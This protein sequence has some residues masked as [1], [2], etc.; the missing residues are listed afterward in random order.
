MRSTLR[1]PAT[2]LLFLAL[3]PIIGSAATTDQ[4][5]AAGDSHTVGIATGGS[6]FTW[7]GN[8]SGQLGD[9]TNTSR[10]VPRRVAGIDNVVSVAAGAAHTLVLKADGTVFSFG[11]NNAGQLGDGTT[12][13]R[14]TPTQVSGLTNIT[15]IAAGGDHSVA[16]RSDGVL[17][18]WGSNGS[19]E[20]GDATTT[21]RS[22]PVQLTRITSVI[23][24]AAGRSHTL[25]LRSDGNAWSW[26]NDSQG[27]L[28]DDDKLATKNV[29]T[30]IKKITGLASIAAGGFHSFAISRT[31]VLYAWGSNQVGQLGDGTTTQRNTPVPVTSLT[32]V[33]KVA[34]GLGHSMAIA[35][36]GSTYAWGDNSVGQLGDGTTSP[37]HAP[38]LVPGMTGL[39]AI[40]A[41]LGHTVV[42]KPGNSVYAWGLNDSGQVGNGVFG[43]HSVAANVLN[44]SAIRQVAAGDNF[45]LA[46]K[47]DGTVS[48]WGDNSF[49]QLGDG[50]RTSR[51]A[52]VAI[53]GLTNVT[54]IAAGARHALA[55]KTDGS[56][57]GWGDNASGQLGDGSTTARL[58]PVRL[59][60]IS[61]VVA[62]AA[63][64]D[65]SVGLRADGTVWEWGLNSSGQ[66]GITAGAPRASPLQVPTLTN[67]TATA[68]G[69]AFTLALRA[70][71]T[72]W[73]WGD[74][75]FGQLGIGKPDLKKDKPTQITALTGIA[76]IF[77]GDAH[78]FAL[79]RNGTLYAWGNNATGQL[80]DG[81]ITQRSSPGTVPGVTNPAVIAGGTDHSLAVKPNGTMSSWGG[82]IL[83]ELGDGTRVAK[84]APVTVAGISNAIAADTGAYF[85]IALRSDGTVVAWGNN[86]SG[87]LGDGTIGR[88]IS[89]VLVLA[90]PS[91][92][93]SSPNDATTWSAGVSIPL[94]A[95][96]SNLA[97]RISKVEYFDGPTKIGEAAV[98]PF[99]VGWSSGSPGQH[100]LT[101]KATDDFGF[102]AV[103]AP[104]AIT[105][106]EADTD[107]NGI[108]DTWE[109]QNFGY[110]G[111]DP[112]ADPD[113]DSHSNLQE[114]MDGT[115]PNDYFNGQS[116]N[117]VVISG[118]N[119][120]SQPGAFLASPFVVKVTN[121]SGAA[122]A[123]APVT[124][125]VIEGGGLIASI[126]N[127]STSATL[128]TRTG[129]DGA[130]IAFYL[131]PSTPQIVSHITASAGAPNAQN[132]AAFA[133]TTDEPQSGQGIT[134]TPDQIDALVGAGASSTLPLTL[135][136]NGSQTIPFNASVV[137]GTVSNLSYADSDQSG[138]PI[139]VWND[140]SLSGT[141]LNAISD[142]DEG[143]EPVNLSFVFPYFNGA[144]AN[145]FV[146]ANGFITLG[147][148]AGDYNYFQF[149]STDGAANEIAAFHTDLNTDDSSGGSGDVYFQDFGDHAIFQ[150]NH[151]ERYSQDG[152]STFQIVLQSDGAIL[153]YYK[154]LTGTIDDCVV[155]IQ[156]ASKN[157]GLT[158]AYQ[159]SYLKN[160]L[161]VRIVETSKW[162][163]VAPPSGS[164][165]AGQSM[166]L[167][168]KLNARDFTSGFYH[169]TIGISSDNATVTPPT[170]PVR[171]A[172]GQTLQVSL[173]APPAG[174]RFVAG[175]PILL[176]AEASDAAGIA[177]VEFFDGATKV[178]E[179]IAPP[180]QGTIQAMTAGSHVLT[181]RATNVSAAVATSLPVQI[182][183]EDDTNSD[184]LGD[185][186]ELE[187]FGTLNVNANDD[188]DGDGLT[189]LQEFLSGTN[190]TQF[191]N[192]QIPD[193]PIVGG[194]QAHVLPGGGAG[195]ALTVRVVNAVGE[196]IPNAPVTFRITR[197]AGQLSITSDRTAP[198]SSTVTVR[199]DGLGYATVYYFAP[200]VTGSYE[201]TAESGEGAIVTQT[202]FSGRITRGK[203]AIIDLGAN[204]T[205]ARIANNGMVLLT[206]GTSNFRW[207][208][209]TLEPFTG[210][211]EDMNN[212]GIVGGY[213]DDINGNALPAT[214]SPQQQILAVP[215]FPQ[216]YINRDAGQ[217]TILCRL[218][219]IGDN[220]DLKYYDYSIYTT[221]EAQTKCFPPLDPN[222]IYG[223]GELGVKVSK[224]G[225]GGV[226]YT[227]DDAG[228]IYS[229]CDP[230]NAWATH[231]L[232]QGEYAFD[233]ARADDGARNGIAMGD[234]SWVWDN[235]RAQFFFS[236]NKVFV[237]RARGTHTIGHRDF[238]FL[239]SISAHTAFTRSSKFQVDGH[240]V[241][242]QPL[243]LN[244]EGFV[245]GFGPQGYLLY[246]NGRSSA[247]TLTSASADETGFPSISAINH[248]TVKITNAAGDL[249]DVESPQMVGYFQNYDTGELRARIWKQDTVANEYVGEDLNNY[250]GDNSDWILRIATDINDRGMI[251]GWADHKIGPN[252]YDYS[253]AVLL[254]PAELMVDGNRDGEMSF[255]DPD[256]HDADGTTAEKPY[257]FWINDDHDTD[258]GDLPVNGQPDG[259][260][261]FIYYKRDLEDFTRLWVTFKG[262]TAL[263]KGAGVTAE[264]QMGAVQQG[265][266]PSIRVFRHTDEAHDYGLGYVS[267][268]AI[269]TAQFVDL[270]SQSEIG[271]VAPGSPLDLTERCPDLI[272]GLSEIHPNLHFLF[273]GVTSGKGKL[274]LVLKK[275]GNVIGIYPALSL[276]LRDI[277]TMY[278]H[279]ALG[280]ADPWTGFTFEA[281]LDETNDA[282]IFVHGW[283]LSPAD[284]ANFAETM[285]KRLWWRGFKGRY[286]AVRWDT[287]YN[288]TDHGWVPYVGQPIDA[289]L[290]RYNDSEHNAWMS[291]QALRNFVNNGLPAG[292][293]RDVVAHSMGNV[294][295]GAA[296][297]QGMIVN[298]YALLNA[299]IPAACYDEDS[300]LR[301]TPTEKNAAILTV[302]LWDSNTTPDDDT[303]SITRALAY[304]GR[305]KNVAGNLIS[306]YL[307]EDYATSYA[308]ELNNV[309][310]KPPKNLA[311]LNRPEYGML[312]TNFEYDRAAS[313][314]RK[315]YKYNFP[316]NRYLSDPNEAEPYACRTWAKALGA[317]GRTR[318]KL[319]GEGVNLGTPAFGGANGLNTEHSGE[320]NRDIQELVPFYREV[321]RQLNIPQNP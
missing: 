87:Q 154:N 253:R 142:A 246:G 145:V 191:Y 204:V 30:Q 140:I 101:A 279:K 6:L 321:L 20:L 133:A 23:G 160:N 1:S 83:G 128:Q 294:V 13:A 259:D 234:I 99:T 236:G 3:L 197:G 162:L 7:G 119:Q 29:P 218:G 123:N 239:V 94:T 62:I 230:P 72:A 81:T 44:L 180:Y 157:K 120:H 320:F 85:S 263:T 274:Q 163:E 47:T 26:G 89:A 200:G 122:L 255:E 2:F 317:E 144:Y 290:S 227:I 158:V 12:A 269:A 309:L 313:P 51:L 118:D 202:T 24:I 276:D 223:R 174:A 280:G 319:T 213:V 187:F 189:N 304:R 305:L 71:G 127:G 192:G 33:E 61:N 298:N 177:R 300:N 102:V 210:H 258:A 52:P 60:A 183:I 77:A 63:G 216:K 281:A 15:A 237:T 134:V 242:F 166:Q 172:V 182:Q 208:N 43:A 205:P 196:P 164:L 86:L 229:A 115:D 292:Y 244:S 130:A 37:R 181:A 147:G 243:T 254:V 165:D 275:G 10:A 315:L 314:G 34:G 238:D 150:F 170:V 190:P 252:Q 67:I 98:S 159:R 104:V 267:D 207:N 175:A 27:Q 148:A 135:T 262:I 88:E 224:V 228:T 289:Y 73:S 296:L 97:G 256:I 249:V 219:T 53:T 287:Y 66:L 50:S 91:V 18:A 65:H 155:G 220:L 124:F 206:S 173:V 8:S 176:Q 93:L 116:S 38:T 268:N 271:L 112:N 231:N 278:Q 185:N 311:P 260:N 297:Q 78:A 307:P 299:A 241:D 14:S 153:F 59:T 113:G 283:R 11:A 40:A 306:F 64:A 96:A 5:V 19:G 151:V 138:G 114:L 265:P 284:T 100:H 291:G 272:N 245:L 270:Q 42:C 251:I 35:N 131:Q 179:A 248:A 69:G 250:I 28:G 156:N 92:T 36:N 286:A 222:G 107:H 203:Y 194:D 103:S 22:R 169:G 45:A 308:W 121:A 288:E 266:N 141:R 106:E 233:Y 109:I 282:I 226:V 302:H 212:S 55:L 75:A 39:T 211:A 257:R 4:Q 152:F 21:N 209:G 232:W 111:V 129:A 48:A 9:G 178:G 301:P 25:A 41:G 16:L 110:I 108:R 80:G 31:G 195:Q 171:M 126:A 199:A 149:P 273:E 264:L 54:S 221:E 217:G 214:W 46:L 225:T 49:G 285:F 201:V 316:F 139:F 310:T 90:L 293:T 295:V 70:D 84:L 32:S 143:T 74:N 215:S 117:L 76:K 240:D 188:L 58:A 193:L 235:L 186:W 247:L 82:N 57:W 161:A 105:I 132:L 303:D 312:D 137:N 318:G 277:K 125:S 198:K 79:N 56:V 168:V 184:G 146:N 17:F 167:M 95:T 68:A 261:A 136:N